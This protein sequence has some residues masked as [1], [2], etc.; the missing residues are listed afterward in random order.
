MALVAV[1]SPGNRPNLRRV[2]ITR[3]LPLAGD[4]DWAATAASRT[5][6]TPLDTSNTVVSTN[7][8][9][10]IAGTSFAIRRDSIF[11]VQSS[12]TTPGLVL[13]WFAEWHEE[14]ACGRSPV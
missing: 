12:T 4:A 3:G 5:H 8:P 2:R 11:S 14:E 10:F 6:L 7:G 13:Q 1:N 9:A